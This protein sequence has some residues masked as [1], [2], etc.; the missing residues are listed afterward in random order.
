MRSSIQ[1]DFSTISSQIQDLLESQDFKEL[2]ALLRELNLPQTLQQL[3][4][5]SA[6]EMAIAYRLLAKEQAL[7]VFAR[8]EPALQAEL[9]SGLQHDTVSETFAVMA[10]D[11]RVAL[12]DELPAHLAATLLQGLDSAQRD[13]V[14]V[15][16]GYRAGVV[17][18]LMNPYFVIT[19]PEL[20]VRESMQRVRAKLETAESVYTL[21]VTDSTRRLRGVVSLRDLLAAKEE[22]LISELLTP[23][24]GVSAEEPVLE[25]ARQVVLSQELLTPVVDSERR[26]VGVFSHSDAVSVLTNSDE[27][28]AARSSGAEPLRRPY[29][30][31]TIG[32]LVRSRIVWLLVLAVGATLTVQVLSNFEETLESM[33]TLSLFIPL[34]VGIGGNTGNQAATTVTRALAMGDVRVG[35]LGRVLLRELGVGLMLGLSLGT[36]GFGVAGFIFEWSIAMII[37]IT[38]VALCTIAAGVGGVMPIIGKWLKVDPAVFSNPFISTFVDAAGLIVYFS[39]AVAVLGH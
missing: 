10:A 33:V 36:I 4:R 29:L 18:H 16:L 22:Q 3:H 28:R 15:L 26:V 25:A 34:M 11:D 6:K 2:A 1:V 31:T 24:D 13:E 8:L 9:I 12:L 32:S 38:L 19:H 30:S 27:Q 7:A 21:V 37:G 17:G 23:G 35:D 20:T 14:N 5:L 39:V